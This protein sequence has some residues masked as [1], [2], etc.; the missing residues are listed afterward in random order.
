M[1]NLELIA[2]Q[3]AELEQLRQ[4]LNAKAKETSPPS[5]LKEVLEDEVI[6]LDVKKATSHSSS[7]RSNNTSRSNK[8]DT[9]FILMDLEVRNQE[10][11]SDLAQKEAMLEESKQQIQELLKR[12][13][14]EQKK[15][16]N[17]AAED[18][19]V[20]SNS[21]MYLQQLEEKDK[22]LMDKQN[23]LEELKLKWEAERAEL[24]KPALDQVNLQLEELKETVSLPVSLA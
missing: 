23:Q 6:T 10:T 24:I 16:E 1:E 8:R 18:S 20:S 5:S 15:E 9:R 7:I 22:L 19:D 4:Q 21:E 12:V 13:E 3:T 2:K 14:L 17:G 11:L